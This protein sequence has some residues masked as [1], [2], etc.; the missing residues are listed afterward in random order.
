MPS[1][2]E[3]PHE[4][5]VS[6]SSPSLLENFGRYSVE[7]AEKSRK[8]EILRYRKKKSFEILLLKLKGRGWGVG[9][10]AMYASLTNNILILIIVPLFEMD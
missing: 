4:E 2:D 10:G 3:G 7:S 9:R 8:L 6:Q 1:L 5:R